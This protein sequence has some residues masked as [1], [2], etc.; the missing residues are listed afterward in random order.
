MFENFPGAQ[1][2]NI[3]E[4]KPENRFMNEQSTISESDY[5]WHPV[6]KE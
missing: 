2:E 5:E 4:K 1:I 3:H 6:E